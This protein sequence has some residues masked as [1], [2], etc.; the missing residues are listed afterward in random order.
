MRFMVKV[1]W[2]VEAGNNLAKAGT[3]G[4][5]VASILADL[6]PEAA[7]FTAEGGKRGGTLIVN[8]DDV[9]QLP[10]VAE[11]WFLAFNASVECLP[12]MLPED[13]EKAGDSIA[14]AVEKY[15]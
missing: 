14:Q 7:Y 6:K 8:L 5:T 2:D 4:S 11:P 1:A 12:V 13:L 3:L 10:A 9:S 15:G